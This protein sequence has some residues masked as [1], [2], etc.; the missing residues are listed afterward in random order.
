MAKEVFQIGEKVHGQGP[1]VFAWQNLHG[2]YLVTSGVNRSV[3]I[4]DRHGEQKEEITLPGQC[5]DL[6]WDQDGD[7]LAIICDKV[8]T[9]FLWD[10]NTHK[11]AQLDTSFKDQLSLCIWAP[12]N[13]LLAAGSSKGNLLIYNHLTQRLVIICARCLSLQVSLVLNKKMM[14][15]YN[16]NNP[17]SPVQLSFQ[18]RYGLIV[19]Y[20]W[21]GD[22]YIMI[23]FS[24]GF[25]VVISTH[26]KEIGQELF[27]AR[28]HRDNLTDIAM[29]QSL[30]KC[31]S[32]GDNSVKI[33]DLSE[34]KEMYAILTLDDERA[35]LD[36]MRWTLDGQLLAVSSTRG[37]LHVFLTRLPTLNAAHGTR[38]AYL[39]SLLE[40]TVEEPK[41]VINIDVEPTFIGLGPYHLAVG[42]NNRIWFYYLSDSGPEHLRDREYLGT[43][44]S[45]KINS[46]HASVLFENKIQLHVIESDAGMP[47]GRETRLFPDDDH[48]D[49]KIACHAIT[50]EFLVYGTD[51][52][53]IYFFYIEDWAFVNTYK[54]VI[55]A[56]KLFPDASGARL[57]FIDDKTDVYI[58]NPV[59]E[60][61]AEVPQVPSTTKGLLWEQAPGD[62]GTF[63][64]YDDEKVYT[65]VHSRETIE[66]SKVDFVGSMK[67]PHGQVPLVLQQGELT[68]QT[69][70]GKLSTVHVE[71]FPKTDN[72]QNLTANELKENISKCIALKKF[73]E[74]WPYAMYVNMKDVWLELGRAAMRNLEVKFAMRVY[75]QLADVSMVWSLEAV[76][77]VE[78]RNLLAGHLASHLDHFELA[79][80]LFLASSEPGAALEM[81]RDLLHWDRALQLAARL[82]PEEI[83]FISR[84]YAQ[85]LEF[86][87]DYGNALTHYEKGLTDDDD[88]NG[89]HNETCKA[90]IARMAIRMGDINRGVA[91]AMDMN[92][93]ALKKEC[94]AILENIKQ[95]GEAAQLYEK[96]EFYDKAASVYIRNKNWS[97]VGDLLP[98]VNSP[99]V[100]AQYA[101]AKESEGK[102][103]D[104]AKAYESAKDW[105]NVVRLYLDHLNNPEE[106]VR[107]VQD[108]QSVEGAKMV[109]STLHRTTPHH[110][111][112]HA[113]FHDHSHASSPL[114][115]P[116]SHPRASTR[117]QPPDAR[118]CAFPW[119]DAKYLFRLYMALQQYRE[120]AR[121][122]IIIAR[123]EQY[124]GNYRS[125][126]DVLY[127]MYRELRLH[128]IT[129]ST[130]MASN[131]MVLH[132]YIL[133]KIHVKRGDHMKAARLLIRVANNISK[134][135]ARTYHDSIAANLPTNH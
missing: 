124:N 42:M 14:Y 55:A 27:Q 114:F 117:R 12:A 1:I 29:C 82:A 135:P 104:A 113:P 23:G 116:T 128:G 34:L 97:K 41:T 2:N 38:V 18:S 130:E 30:N 24:S 123:E 132:S 7:T 84:E 83:T 36:R 126:H 16:M 125:A 133:V 91:M 43:V 102:Y 73:K 107:I 129:V 108:T 47:E 71:A 87:G 62:M 13:Q 60:Q 121:T 51:S 115:L 5:I 11:V 65:Y 44:Q 53:A 50:H 40:V 48:G 103:K 56:R 120:A 31:A 93:K 99:K 28:N 118:T 75:R 33:H 134:F 119:Q 39:T 70:N 52:G 111:A 72:P 110:T 26:M 106:A 66:G 95:F 109:A 105:D 22:G 90:G 81:R 131:L 68:L 76:Q 8:G 32:C 80:E 74:A 58:L 20:K 79:Q 64:M 77:G 49:E 85:Q 61:L 46:E 94:A 37:T 3:N 89:D 100:H 96:G 9:V 25:F 98:K 69:Q 59:N 92:G 88:K 10:A 54:H 17:D 67:I 15:M 127:S 101:K 21:F 86:V 35:P 4:F 57:A 112:S 6:G 19:S 45:V 63:V 122:A 78:D